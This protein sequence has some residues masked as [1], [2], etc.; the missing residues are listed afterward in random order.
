MP[1]KEHASHTHGDGASPSWD[2]INKRNRK[3]R[4]VAKGV[5]AYAERSCKPKTCTKET[6]SVKSN[7]TWNAYLSEKKGYD[8]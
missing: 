3:Q 4:Q 8:R 1:Q 5:K 2:A 7:C 6:C